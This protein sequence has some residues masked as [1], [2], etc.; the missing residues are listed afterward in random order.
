MRC[1]LVLVGVVL[2]RL[3]VEEPLVEALARTEDPA[4]EKS[5]I[6][7]LHLRVING[8]QQLRRTRRG[9]VSAVYCRQLAEDELLSS[10]T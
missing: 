6:A 3:V 8:L 7:L 4:F 9:L 5:T 10:S 2:E 1:D